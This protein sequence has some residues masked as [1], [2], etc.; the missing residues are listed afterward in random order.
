MQTEELKV[1]VL[2]HKI[3]VVIRP[4]QGPDVRTVVIVNGIATRLDTLDGL[5]DKMDPSLEIIRF[6]PPGIGGSW[7]WGIPYGIPAVAAGVVAILDKL[8]RRDPV[9]VVG[10][11]WG[12]VVAQ[13]IALQSPRRVRRLVLLS[14]NT[15]VMSVPGSMQSMAMMMNP[16]MAQISHTDDK[17]IGDIYGGLAR[18]R[19]EDVRQL[20]K[21]DLESHAQGL[22]LQ[23][24]AAMT[25]TT[26]PMVR[27]IYQPTMI[28]AGTDD[29]MV[30]MLNARM[31]AD[32]IPAGRLYTHEGGHLEAL[33]DPDRFGPMI[34]KFLTAKRPGVPD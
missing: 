5:V 10:Y 34:S 20:L 29:P 31:L 26:L 28:L 18:Q 33:L 32:Q 23:L 4:G 3:R 15:G 16:L 21:A 14:S 11:S 7:S 19:A 22:M 30:P 13:Q 24:L 9:D 1:A 12:G 8:G 25:W 27:F 6:D 17:A 2:G